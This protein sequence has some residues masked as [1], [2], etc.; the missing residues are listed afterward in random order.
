MAEGELKQLQS[1]D[2]A[3]IAAGRKLHAEVTRLEAALEAIAIRQS[4]I[5]KTARLEQVCLATLPFAHHNDAIQMT[6]KQP[7]HCPLT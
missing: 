6:C 5:V 3:Q 4:E 7:C 2:S 1:Q